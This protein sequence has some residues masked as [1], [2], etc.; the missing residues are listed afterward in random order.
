MRQ[1]AFGLSYELAEL[2]RRALTLPGSICHSVTLAGQLRP[3][4]K[5]HSLQ[6]QKTSL[7]LRTL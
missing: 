6:I 2:A 7:Q 1:I 5:R 4:H 3:S